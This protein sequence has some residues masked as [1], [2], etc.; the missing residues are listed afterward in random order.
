MFKTNYTHIILALEEVQSEELRASS[1]DDSTGSE[2]AQSDE[3][4]A[5]ATTAEQKILGLGILKMICVVE[6][7]NLLTICL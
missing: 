5:K 3:V 1:R 4:N 2:N 7:N 6:S